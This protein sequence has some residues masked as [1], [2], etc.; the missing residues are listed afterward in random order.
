MHTETEKSWGWRPFELSR[1]TESRAV[2]ERHKN[3]CRLHSNC[4]EADEMVRAAGGRRARA[5]AW[6][7]QTVMTA[8][9]AHGGEW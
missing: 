5:G 6:G 2:F 9:H 7:W 1:E 8:E 3:T 4:A